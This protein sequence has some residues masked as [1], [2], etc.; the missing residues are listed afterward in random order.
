MDNNKKPIEF[1][2]DPEDFATR[3]ANNAHFE[4][5]VWDMK[6]TFGQTDASV[7]PN[8]VIQHTAITIPWS[9]AKVVMYLLQVNIAAQEA[10]FGH[11][12]VPPNILAKPNQPTE[13]VMAGLRHP[14]EAVAA[15]RKVWDDFVS[16]NPE[17][18]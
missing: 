14:K 17:L 10:E 3:Y 9:Y 8:V 11:I 6:M 5:S 2:R 7:G 15:V 12:E 16:A 18:K 1:K 13:E 4:T